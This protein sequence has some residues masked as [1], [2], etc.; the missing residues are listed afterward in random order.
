MNIYLAIIED[1]H[2]DTD[3]Y[4]FSTAE[5]AIAFAKREA[6]D[7]ARGDV[8]RIE[9]EEIENWLYSATYSTE[10]DSVR[11][12]ERLVDDPDTME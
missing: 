10:G 6:L 3:V 9:E 8:S 12:I 5:A 1:R 7:G 11:V 2:T 4:P